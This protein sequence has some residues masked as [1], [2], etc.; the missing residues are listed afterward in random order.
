[1]LFLLPSVMLVVTFSYYP[2]LSAL[3][4]SFFAWDGYS[5]PVFTGIANF[6]TLLEDPIIIISV[7]NMLV[8]ILSA[9]GIT[10][11]L[12]LLAAE[13]VYHVRNERMQYLY[14][15][16]FIIPMVVPMVVTLLVWQFAYDPNIGIL[17]T[18]LKSIGLGNLARTWLAD[19]RIALY[20]IIGVGF[21][22][23]SGLNFLLYLAALQNISPDIRDSCAL[24]GVGPLKKVLRIDLPIIKG[25]VRVLVVL[26]VIGV[27]Q[28]FI[29]IWV[30]TQGGPAGATMV[31]SVALYQNGFMYGNFGYASAIGAALFF[32]TLILTFINMRVIRSD[33]GAES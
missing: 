15:V 9:V 4:H 29:Q 10:L 27:L 17:N 6:R 19:P 26:A 18:L 20:A 14:R 12:P 16:L 1:M 33:D 7:K 11:T 31:P 28:A 21:P 13:L 24:D 23:V 32:V 2:A 22:W 25:Q 5:P 30:L 3:Y 8:L